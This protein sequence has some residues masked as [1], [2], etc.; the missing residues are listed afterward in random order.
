LSEEPAPEL[1]RPSVWGRPTIVDVAI[2][3]IDVDA[4]RSAEQSFSASVFYAAGWDIPVLRHEG[5]GPL[6]R[7]ITDVWTLRLAIVNQQQA[8]P[9]F[10]PYVEISPEGYV[11]FRQKVWGNFSQPLDLR[12]FPFDSQTLTIHLVSAGLLETEVT[13]VPFAGE[14]GRS[15]SISPDFSIPDFDVVSWTAEPREPRPFFPYEGEVG[16]AGFIMEIELKRKYE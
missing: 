9:A 5:P 10:P 1:Q 16:T 4:L 8:W 14:H 13:M 12:D 6:I 11:T 2:Y 7:R 15:S 3:V